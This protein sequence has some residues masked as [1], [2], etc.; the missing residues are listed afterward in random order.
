MPSVA[1]S[2]VGWLVLPALPA[3]AA[4]IVWGL[5]QLAGR[6]AA[7]DPQLAALAVLLGGPAAGLAAIATRFR[8]PRLV[9]LVVAP[10]LLALVL[11]GRVLIG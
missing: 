11:V 2:S 7:D 8:W 10:A 1:R 3:F 4:L 5:P 9:P 6:G